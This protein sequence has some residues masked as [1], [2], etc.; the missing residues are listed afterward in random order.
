MTSVVS[1]L[2]LATDELV[3][4][5]PRNVF[6]PVMQETAVPIPEKVRPSLV[7][8]ESGSATE[9]LHHRRV[10]NVANAAEGR[11]SWGMA[12]TRDHQN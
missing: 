11:R 6:H 7:I 5:L 2:L 3:R 9:C 12:I 10:R 4:G 1:A 8:G